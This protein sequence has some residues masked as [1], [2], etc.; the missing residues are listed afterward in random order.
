MSVRTVTTGQLPPLEAPGHPSDRVS[1]LIQKLVAAATAEVESAAQRARA[2]AETELAELRGTIDRLRQ[3]LEDEHDRQQ[4]AIAEL[5]AARADAARL[6][7]ELEAE[8][9]DKARFAATLETVRLL[10]SGIDA[11][12]HSAHPA[13]APIA[14]AEADDELTRE[15]I[16]RDEV[17]SGNSPSAASSSENAGPDDHLTQLMSQI[18]DIYRADLASADGTSDVVARLA[19]NLEYARGA[20]AGRIA[21]EQCGD[22]REFDRELAALIDARSDTPFGRHL[23][24]AIRSMTRDR[25]AASELQHQSR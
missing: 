10:V 17:L 2:Q 7:G 14:V 21:S 8:R 23:A 22:V 4:S 25:S 11:E 5:S 20:Y 9:T 13:P 3:E 19:A 16:D 12:V 1:D 18:E 15:E 24:M 6:A